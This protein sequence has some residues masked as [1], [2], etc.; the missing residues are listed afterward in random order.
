M[1]ASISVGDGIPWSSIEEALS[2]DLE[3]EV[4]AARERKLALE[5]AA[6]R[7]EAEAHRG[8]AAEWVAQARLDEARGRSEDAA[9]AYGIAFRL[10]EAAAAAD[11]AARRT[12][13]RLTALRMDASPSE[14]ALLLRRAGWQS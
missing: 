4:A 2:A 3:A 7:A 9:R 11:A 8:N 10:R 5:C 12:S 1:A 6:Y 14:L 13:A